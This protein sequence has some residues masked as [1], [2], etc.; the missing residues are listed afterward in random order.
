MTLAR[1]F[2]LLGAAAGVLCAQKLE[3]G[4]RVGA[5]FTSV[6]TAGNS[7]SEQTTPLTVGP[8]AELLLPFGLGLEVDALYR[9]FSY[10]RTSG[11]FA[12]T[13]VRSNSWEFPLLVKYRAPGVFVRPF[14][15]GGLSFRTLQGL[16]QFGSSL[17]PGGD[18]AELRNN[19]SRGL[20]LG[21]GLEVHLP[22]VRLSPELRFTHWG[23]KA[24]QSLDN[25][26]S[27]SSRQNQLDLLVG[28]TF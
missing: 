22:F 27:L 25:G 23:S 11:Q 17:L 12:S 16:T 21:A 24:F 20:V 26:A 3:W 6:L 28:I 8:T 19:S 18:P 13:G 1:V 15:D 9:R 10:N 5:P 4:A 14:A 2:I 7:Y